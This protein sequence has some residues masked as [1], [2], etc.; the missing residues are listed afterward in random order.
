MS[1]KE[2]LYQERLARIQRTIDLQPV[3][4]IPFVFMGTAFAPRYMGV[5]MADF[6]ADPDLRVEVTLAAMDRLGGEFDGIN[7]LPAGRIHVALSAAWL[8]RV[9]VPGRD[10]P[11]ESLWQVAEAEVMT[12]DDYDTIIDRG[13][14]AFLGEYLPRI[15]D[16][17]DLEAH[18]NWMGN[19]LLGVVR[20][21]RERG[22]VPVSGG[23]TTI[24]FE[25]LCGGR[26][27]EEFFL[28]L[29]RIPDKVKA[30]LDAMQPGLIQ[31][32]LDGARRSGVPAVWVGGWRAASAMLSP[33][34]W[35]EFV[36]PYYLETVNRL[37]ENDVV[38]VLHFDHDWTRDLSRLRELP[39]RRCILN[40][41]GWTDIRRAKEILGDHMAI[42]GDVPAP[43]LSTGTP[44]EVRAYVRDLARE[45]GPTGLILC[46]GCDAP[47]DAKPENMQAFAAASLE[48]GSTTA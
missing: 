12:V 43:L 28:D 32:G 37:A 38:S 26:S 21:C 27:L 1:D 3:D 9:A 5:S 6:C 34:M 11:D 39:A 41:D 13:W 16:P 33:K 40:L 48:F 24:P 14:L 44:D 45:V 2:S 22:Y 19:H 25:C 10:L 36:F 18:A 29:H 42:M 31:I 17:A 46:P 4:R 15:I 8:S 23:G 35:N 47:I 30:A 20:R 7:S